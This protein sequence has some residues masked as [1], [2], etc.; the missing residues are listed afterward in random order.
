MTT[1][2]TERIL[3]KAKPQQDGNLRPKRNSCFWWR[4]WKNDRGLLRIGSLVLVSCY[5]DYVAVIFLSVFL[6]PCPSLANIPK[7]ILESTAH[8]RCEHYL[9]TSTKKDCAVQW[10]EKEWVMRD[11]KKERKESQ[12]SLGA[13]IQRQREQEELWTPRNPWRIWGGRWV[14]LSL[15]EEILIWFKSPKWQNDPCCHLAYIWMYHNLVKP[16]LMVF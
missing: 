6:P 8:K 10:T 3:E 16:L 13:G 12:C 9:W 5:V 4:S 14:S 1:I 15:W 2:K 11:I 7:Q